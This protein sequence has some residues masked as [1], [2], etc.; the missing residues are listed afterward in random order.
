MPSAAEVIGKHIDPA[1]ISC[2]HKNTWRCSFCAVTICFLAPTRWRVLLGPESRGGG[3]KCSRCAKPR[4]NNGRQN[5]G[6]NPWEHW[7]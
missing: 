5:C 1:S 4:K 2:V 6:K 7:K 3:S